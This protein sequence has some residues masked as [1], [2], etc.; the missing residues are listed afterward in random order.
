MNHL[1]PQQI[2]ELKQMLIEWKNRIIEDTKAQ[3][4]EALSFEGSDE[5]ERAE[6]ETNRIITLRTLDRE[7]KLLKKIE[8]TLLKIEYG[9]YGI[10]ESC[11]AQ[12]P[13]ERLKARPVASLCINC[14]LKQEE[15]EE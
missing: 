4:G 6:A 14:K 1:T 8:N 9:V 2:E 10:C 5:M 13:Y 7:R 12:I 3:T 11:G 15:E